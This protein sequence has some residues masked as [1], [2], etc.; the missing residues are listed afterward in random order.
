MTEC[1]MYWFSKISYW[2]AELTQYYFLIIANHW[3]GHLLSP[4]INLA[5]EI[6]THFVGHSL[7]LNSIIHSYIRFY[8]S[9]N[10]VLNF[11]KIF[12]NQKYHL[13]CK[14]KM[15]KCNQFTCLTWILFHL[16][17]VLFILNSSSYGS[18]YCFS[19]LEHIPLFL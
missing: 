17:L 4:A 14:W 10:L 15:K 13:I 6:L 1:L 3:F 2:I 8:P 9:F 18:S 16:F 5:K 19:G 11:W 7:L 12:K